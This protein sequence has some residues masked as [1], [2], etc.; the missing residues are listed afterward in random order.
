MCINYLLN[1]VAIHDI[2]FLINVGCG[3]K[4]RDD[5]ILVILKFITQLLC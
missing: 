2:L 5:F 4:I 1:V 3:S